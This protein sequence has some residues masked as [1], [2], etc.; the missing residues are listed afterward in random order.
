MSTQTD[1]PSATITLKIVRLSFPSLFVPTKFGD[2]QTTKYKAVFILDKTAHA[3]AIAQINAT[4]ALM[5]KSAKVK[6]VSSYKLCLRDGSEK[7]DTD[8]YGE[9]VMFLSASNPKAISVV[10]RDLTPLSQDSGKPYAGCFVNVH[11]R[12]WLQDNKWGK[13]INAKLST[14]QF[15]GDGETFG[16]KA[17]TASDVFEDLSD[18]AGGLM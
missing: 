4:F 2:E 3:D 1:T 9:K 16:E 12:L 15:F 5:V 7:P 14:V 18:S 10:D 13:R 11:L 17:V 6:S 8:G